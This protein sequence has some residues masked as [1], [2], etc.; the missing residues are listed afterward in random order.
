LGK[1][2]KTELKTVFYSLLFVW[3]AQTLLIEM[4]VSNPL[5]K[6]WLL[7]KTFRICPE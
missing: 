2:N 5:F 1:P 3:F 4:N 6:F 7:K